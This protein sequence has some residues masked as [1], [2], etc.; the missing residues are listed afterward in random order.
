[1][2]LVTSKSAIAQQEAGGRTIKC[3]LVGCGAQG[4]TLRISSATV[5]GIQWVAVADVW[6]YNRNPVA[7]RMARAENKHQVNGSI[8]QYDTIEELLDKE[9]ELDAVFIATPD[10]LHAPFSRMALMKGKAV[11]CEKMMSN[12]IEGA[13]DM[14]KA[15][16]ETGGIFQIGHQRHSNPRY[17]HL[18]DKVIKKHNMLGRITH[19]YGQWNRGVSQSVPLGMPKGQEIAP[20][21]LA[22]YGYEDAFQF[23]NWR[24]FSKYGGGP[25]A[26]LGAHQIDMFN[27]TFESTPVSIIA[28]GGVD[29][30]DGTDGRAKYELPDNVMCIYEYNLSKDATKPQV[31]RAYYQVL[32]TTSSQ[33]AYEKYMGINGAAVISELDKN[34]NQVYREASAPAWDEFAEGANPLVIR[35]P[36]SVYNKIWEKNK[37]WPPWNRPEPWLDIRAGVADVR[38]SKGLDPFELPVVLIGRPHSPHIQ[39]FIEAVQM[40]KYEHLTCPVEMAFKSCVTVL[41]AY[42]SIKTGAKVVFKPEDFKV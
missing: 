7:L 28:T 37:A 30:Y 38:E 12:T 13:R 26:D 29:Y 40:K 33:G 15:Q 4:E 6:K 31:A 11:Y 24:F 27:W 9:K 34:G 39:N 42:E 41:S 8:N 21:F 22:K 10:F 1:M 5:P 17:L 23:R 25:I 32:T 20:E 2:L 19:A 36:S 3:A 14:V 18:R 35:A 16:Q